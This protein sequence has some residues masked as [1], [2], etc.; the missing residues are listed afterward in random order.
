MEYHTAADILP[1][2]QFTN[3]NELYKSYHVTGSLNYVNKFKRMRKK[4]IGP[5][6]SKQPTCVSYN[7]YYL[8]RTS[9]ILNEDMNTTFRGNYPEFFV[10]LPY[11]VEQQVTLFF[12]FSW[13]AYISDF[14]FHGNQ[15]QCRCHFVT[16]VNND[17][18]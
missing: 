12:P 18:E 5:L 1:E 15:Q 4:L 3:L 8:P 11:L 6:F 17:A 9:F 2:K 10:F 7:T 13:I 16:Y 14:P